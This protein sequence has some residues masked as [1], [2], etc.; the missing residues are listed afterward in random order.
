M[1]SILLTSL[2]I[3]VTTMASA[4]TERTYYDRD[5]MATMA[6]KI[7]QHDW[8]RAQVDAVKSAAEWYLA[9]SDQDTWDFVPPPEQLRAINV[10]I[11]HDCPFCGDEITRKAGHYP[12]I[13]DRENPFK[14]TCPVCERTFPDND[15]EPWN[16][17]GLD[18]T[19]ESGEAIIDKGLGWIGPDDRRYYF[20]SYYIF[21]QRW[22]EDILDGM[23][24]LGR[25]YLV[26]G[27]RGEDR[28]VQ[29]PLER[30]GGG[31]GLAGR[32]SDSHRLA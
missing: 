23:S 6:E 20:V 15:F 12:W 21:W 16:T 32:A 29:G 22:Y 26:T 8:A 17:E 10:C 24:T 18:G 5:V 9:R 11:A 4:K 19:P 28:G 13:M 1:K 3:A 25:A 27:D 7:A 31:G 2:L 14:V 30:G